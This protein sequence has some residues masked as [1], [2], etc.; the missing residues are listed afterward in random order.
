MKFVIVSLGLILSM[1]AHA[2]LAENEGSGDIQQDEISQES[3]TAIKTWSKAMAL[4]REGAAAHV[5]KRCGVETSRKMAEIM[6]SDTAVTGFQMTQYGETKIPG[7]LW[8]KP[9]NDVRY[10]GTF[11]PEVS[12]ALNVESVACRNVDN[13]AKFEC[14][15]GTSDQLQAFFDRKI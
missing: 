15:T 8:K 13:S 11:N 3:Q 1:T 2:Q 7:F 10:L 4:C 14:A 9:V 6:T 12:R 5:A